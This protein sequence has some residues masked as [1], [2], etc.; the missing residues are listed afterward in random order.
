M[1]GSVQPVRL[2]SVVCL[3]C[4]VVLAAKK[5]PV[6]GMPAGAAASREYNAALKVFRFVPSLEQK[7]TVES[8]FGQ[9]KERHIL[10]KPTLYKLLARADPEQLIPLCQKAWKR[11]REK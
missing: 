1:K 6:R 8:L 9:L 4:S 2:F 11:M 10:I 7:K 5:E 3:L